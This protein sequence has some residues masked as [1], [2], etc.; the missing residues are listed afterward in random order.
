MTEAEMTDTERVG[1][2]GGLSVVSADS[3]G[4][5]VITLCGEIDYQTCGPLRQA[6]EASAPFTSRVVA[7]LR[8]VGFMDSTGINILITA[9]H[10]FTAAGGWL[11]L[12][13]PTAAVLRV[14]QLVGVDALIDCHDTLE[15]ALI[16]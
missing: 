6:F 1:Q 5:R 10:G 11:R 2:P 7:D 3:D 13:A 12:A 4:I 16:P 9:H 14:I 8:G 15:Q